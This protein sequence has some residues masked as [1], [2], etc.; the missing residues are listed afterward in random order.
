MTLYGNIW[1]IRCV[2]I[3]RFRETK[4]R[5]LDEWSMGDDDDDDDDDDDVDDGVLEGGV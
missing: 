2:C 1:D 4:C 3:K 5:S